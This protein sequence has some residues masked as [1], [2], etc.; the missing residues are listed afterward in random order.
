MIIHCLS[1]GKSI[2][3]HGHNCPYCLSQVNELT[4]ELNGI[5]EKPGFKEKMKQLVFGLAHKGAEYE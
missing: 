1:C 5:Q 2:S 3:S 4:L